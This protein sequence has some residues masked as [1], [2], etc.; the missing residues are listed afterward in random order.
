MRTTHGG[1]GDK[2]VMVHGVLDKTRDEH[3]LGDEVG[4]GH[5]VEHT[6]DKHCVGAMGVHGDEVAGTMKWRRPMGLFSGSAAFS[7]IHSYL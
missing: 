5:D 2:H 7:C 1:E 3:H 4:V 6:D